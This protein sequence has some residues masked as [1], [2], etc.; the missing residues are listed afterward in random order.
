[1]KKTILAT[2]LLSITASTSAYAASNDG[3]KNCPSRQLPVVIPNCEEVKDKAF[4]GKDLSKLGFIYENPNAQ[5][6]LGLELPGL[7]SFGL[8]VGSLDSCAIAKSITSKTIGRQLDKISGMIPNDIGI[9][10][11]IGGA[12]EDVVNGESTGQVINI[13]K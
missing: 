12:A 5:C 4:D 8:D 1:M 7:P 9:G 6:D 2:I 3:E 13:Y 10:A 11:D